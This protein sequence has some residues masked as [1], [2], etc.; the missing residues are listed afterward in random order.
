MRFNYYNMHRFVRI[1][2]MLSLLVPA[3]A[4]AANQLPPGYAYMK[5]FYC[6]YG[7]IGFQ[8]LHPPPGF[9]NQFAV[10]V[11]EVNSSIEIKNAPA[12]DVTLFNSTEKSAKTK[13]L[14]SVEVFDEPYVAGEGSGAYYLN[15]DPRGRT[16]AWNGTIPGGMIHLR[17]R[18]ALPTQDMAAMLPAYARCR[19]TIG[20]YSVDGPTDGEWPTG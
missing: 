1:L 9:E 12:P 2:A 18:V 19:V 6:A 4:H 7:S 16:H 17:V 10:A 3:S 8:P 20:P 13:R 15:T 14:I 11:I 5:L